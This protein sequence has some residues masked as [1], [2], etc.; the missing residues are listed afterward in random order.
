MSKAM[1]SG[2]ER[3]EQCEVETHDKVSGVLVD[4]Q[5]RKNAPPFG[6]PD[7]CHRHTYYR[8]VDNLLDLIPT[9]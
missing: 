5:A 7:P 1:S 4:I 8:D 2:E 6:H 3:P 9:R